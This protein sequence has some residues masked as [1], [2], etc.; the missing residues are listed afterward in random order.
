M[1]Y[2]D[3]I[4][5]GFETFEDT[6]IAVED[7]VFEMVLSGINKDIIIIPSCR[8]SF[9]FFFDGTDKV[10]TLIGQQDSL[11][12]KKCAVTELAIPN[13]MLQ[14]AYIRMFNLINDFSRDCEENYN[15]NPVTW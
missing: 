14:F 8:K 1:K 10:E 3:E 15:M 2:I 4:D 6:I 11:M 7:T 5:G 13:N 9:E 12:A